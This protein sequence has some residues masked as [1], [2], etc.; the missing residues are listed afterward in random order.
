[1]YEYNNNL[2]VNYWNII[3]TID[4]EIHFMIQFRNQW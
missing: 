2:L 1:M 4:Y 3:N